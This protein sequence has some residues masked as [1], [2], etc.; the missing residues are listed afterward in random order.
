MF[1]GCFTSASAAAEEYTSNWFYQSFES[2][3]VKSEGNK[4][5]V[6]N[7]SI[8]GK[9]IDVMT[10]EE[11]GT[12]T[13]NHIL[14]KE[15][16]TYAIT[17]EG[18]LLYAYSSK[19]KNKRIIVMN[20]KGKIKATCPIEL[21][22]NK[23]IKK[24][25]DVSRV[26]IADLTQKD[27]KIYYLVSILKKKDDPVVYLQSY[28]IKS[29]KTTKYK[30]IKYGAWFFANNKLYL[31]TTHGTIEQYT[32]KGR[33]ICSCEIPEGEIFITCHSLY[34]N[35][36]R[37]LGFCSLDVVG[38]YIYYCNRNGVYKCDT[39]GTRTFELIYSGADDP[40]FNPKYGE[41]LG[42]RHLR[43]L[44]N[45]NFHLFLEDTDYVVKQV[46]YRAKEE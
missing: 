44:E 37:E 34:N 10:C 28:D 1:A 2:G 13:Y 32:L 46:I 25:V 35:F 22:L 17:Q 24:E 20:E 39:K 41:E 31:Y 30:R 19:G 36:T 21:K 43:V 18:S 16:R 4:V 5:R 3:Y 42:V 6:I 9:Y 8:G 14:C 29:K 45:G 26:H 33:K 12:R 15:K 27:N 40:V 11:D 38:R 7:S 23:K